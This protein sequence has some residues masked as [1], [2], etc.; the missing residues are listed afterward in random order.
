MN[1]PITS[2]FGRRLALAALVLAMVGGSV[3]LVA[4]AL[5]STQAPW[6]ISG[7]AQAA[8]APVP[9]QAQARSVPVEGVPGGAALGQPGAK[10]PVRIALTAR[11]RPRPGA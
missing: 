8:A 5:S 9:R 11:K 6:K 10:G 7:Q 2:E 1:A 4:T 3:G